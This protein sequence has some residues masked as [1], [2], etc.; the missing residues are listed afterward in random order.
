MAEKTKQKKP[1][2]KKE[3]QYYRT[4][5]GLRAYNYK[6][7]YMSPIE[8]ILYFLLAFIAG[9]AVGYLF[10]GGL[11]KNEFGEPTVL[12]Y[13][14]NVLISGAV[15]IFAGVMFIPMRTKQIIEKQ[16]NK[17]NL[18]FRD[19]L[20]TLSTNFGAGKNAPDSFIAAYN[21][22]K[23]QYDES[24]YVIKELQIIL[25]SLNN[26]GKIEDCLASLGERSGLE[27]IIS[28]ANVFRICKNRGGNYKDTI[29]ATY[30][31]ISD[32][33]D[34]TE[35]IKTVVTSS[36]TEQNMML[37]MPIIL[38]ALIKAA[39]SDFANN[40]TTTYGIL[41]TTVGVAMFILA[42]FIGKKILDIKM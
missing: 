36:K 15:G 16:R 3:P 38:I 26:N 30:E 1:A 21:D 4:D 29:R 33:I 7:Y 2:P 22:I 17:L 18:Q 40:F 28:F 13:V 39:S 8:K 19:L 34:V 6:V 27:D 10:Y 32:K 42:Y 24:A 35:D 11:A 23:I 5:T 37:V 12:T 25:S 41:A 20:E 14:L 9:A 31:I